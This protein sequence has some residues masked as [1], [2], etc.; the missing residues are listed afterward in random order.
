MELSPEREFRFLPDRRFRF[1]FAF[2][3]QKVAVEVEGG[4][5]VRGRHTRG[6]GFLSDLEKYN[7]AQTENWVVLRFVPEQI[8]KDPEGCI[9]MVRKALR[10]KDASASC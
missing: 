8:E 1:D 9:G 7:L 10:K 5:W 6:K 3:K 2:P 4:A